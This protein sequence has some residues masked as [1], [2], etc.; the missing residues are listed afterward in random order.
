MTEKSCL[1]LCCF[2][3]PFCC[4]ICYCQCPCSCCCLRCS[5]CLWCLRC[6]CCRRLLWVPAVEVCAVAGIPIVVYIPYLPVLGSR[7]SSSLLF[8]CR[9]CCCCFSYCCLTSLKCLLSLESALDF[10]SEACAFS[11]SG[12]PVLIVLLFLLAQ[13]IRA[14][15]TRCELHC[16]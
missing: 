1:R 14:Q 13:R 9:S 12:V 2:W 3:C 11:I 4:S 10:S 7:F 5:C 15:R 16:G 8:C 6:Y